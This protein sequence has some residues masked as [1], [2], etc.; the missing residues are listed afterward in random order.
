MARWISFFQNPW[1]TLYYV[2][3][4]VYISPEYINSSPPWAFKKV[5]ALSFTFFEINLKCAWGGFFLFQNVNKT[6][7]KEQQRARA[8]QSPSKG[9]PQN[10][11]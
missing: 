11:L 3:V 10:A 2:C 9:R 4:R 1:K 6:Q 7:R 8:L 5:R